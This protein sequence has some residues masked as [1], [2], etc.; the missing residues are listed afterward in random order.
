MRAGEAAKYGEYWVTTTSAEEVTQDVTR[1]S[2]LQR[3]HHKELTA[4]CMHRHH[5]ACHASQRKLKAA[6]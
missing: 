1:R 3:K 2:L 5:H 6:C 4:G